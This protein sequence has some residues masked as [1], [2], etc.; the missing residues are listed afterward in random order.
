VL[1]GIS[2]MAQ[3][4]ADSDQAMG[5]AG[6]TSWDRCCQGLPTIMLVLAENQRNIA[7]AL[8]EAGA[9]CLVDVSK[10]NNQ[11]LIASECLVPL[12][13]SAMSC[14]VAAITDGFGAAQVNENLINKVEHANQLAL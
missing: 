10:L 9:A 2:D 12:S 8:C 7:E 4:M 3:L 11:P 1:V 13:L 14:A 5:A 6:A